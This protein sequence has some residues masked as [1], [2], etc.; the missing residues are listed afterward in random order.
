MAKKTTIMTVE[1]LEI[2]F[3]ADREQDYFSLTD[4]AKRSSNRPEQVIQNWLR[5]RIDWLDAN[6]P[7]T[8]TNLAIP[9]VAPLQNELGVYPNPSN[10]TFNVSF[11]TNKNENA[12]WTI[13][14]NLGQVVQTKNIHFL[15]GK[16]TFSV[17]ENLLPGTYCF[18]IKNE[19]GMWNKTIIKQ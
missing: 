4:L 18:V 2:R 9:G 14:N 6:M 12:T 5:N 17:D 15:A 11:I 13:L 19:T 16:N 3:H 7:G 10:T 8:C 1:G